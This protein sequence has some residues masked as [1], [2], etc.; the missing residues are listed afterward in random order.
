MKKR[1][2]FEKEADIYA[3]KSEQTKLAGIAN[4][5]LNA[6]SS[7]PELKPFPISDMETF[8]AMA[9]N[10][11]RF[12]REKIGN[13][14]AE[15]LPVVAG[16]LDTS[17]VSSIARIPDISRLVELQNDYRHSLYGFNNLIL[18]GGEIKTDPAYMK[19]IEENNTFFANN[20]SELEAWN[21]LEQ[22]REGLQRLSKHLYLHD[23]VKLKDMVLIRDG[24]PVDINQKF[25]MS[26][27]KNIY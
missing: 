8:T 21:A 11:E 24:K 23:F 10:P 19:Q 25:W 17:A 5:F 27:R 16:I 12:I 7:I 4:L 14:I 18:E 1:K 6:Y 22:V 26:N 3:A 2:L 13:R 9:E 20:E 15:Q